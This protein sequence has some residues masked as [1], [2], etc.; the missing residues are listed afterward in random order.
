[1]TAQRDDADRGR[2][3]AW[4]RN[5]EGS[6]FASATA[7]IAIVVLVKSPCRWMSR[8]QA[9]PR[10]AATVRASGRD[11]PRSEEMPGPS[12]RASVTAARARQPHRR[13]AMNH[14]KGPHR[15]ALVV[16]ASAQCAPPASTDGAPA[17]LG[18]RR[19]NQIVKIRNRKVTAEAM[20]MSSA[21]AVKAWMSTSRL[22]LA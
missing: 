12:Q 10:I 19:V 14:E 15:A 17:I 7:E 1:M 3:N 22:M 8:C 18:G 2:A 6:V 20:K 16:P 9:L 4:H 13:S 21:A 5:F 11:K